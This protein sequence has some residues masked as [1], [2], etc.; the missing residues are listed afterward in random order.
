MANIKVES[1]RPLFDGMAIT[2]KAPCECS[3]VD[4]LTVAYEGVSQN[5]V[6]R[7]AHGNILTGIGN[8][9]EE[10]AYVQAI[11]D[12]VNGHAYLQNA[13]TNSYLESK[14]W[15][16]S[17]EYPGCYYRITASGVKEWQNPPMVANTGYRTSERFEGKTVYVVRV[18]VPTLEGAGK[19]ATVN[20]NFGTIDRV[21]DISTTYYWN[22][23][24]QVF[25]TYPDPLVDVDGIH[26]TTDYQMGT[27]MVHSHTDFVKG[28]TAYCTVKFT[29]A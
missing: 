12:T 22:V 17:D 23:G 14:F 24:T 4:G 7:D 1:N 6:F 2:F 29:L 11:L 18:V 25:T 26:A 19:V 20:L 16:E 9:F 27:L 28:F 15:K 21:L 5:F 13:D 10:G 8:L 3:A